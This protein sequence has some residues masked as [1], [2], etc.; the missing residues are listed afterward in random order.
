MG[1][2]EQILAI[3][4]GLTVTQELLHA[5]GDQNDLATAGKGEEAAVQQLH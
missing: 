3:Q 1:D 2:L 4:I 5:G